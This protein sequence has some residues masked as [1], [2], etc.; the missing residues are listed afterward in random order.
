MHKIETK[1]AQGKKITWIGM[2]VNI[3][4]IAM[5]FAAGVFGHSQA[6]IADAI[7]SISDFFTDFVVVLGLIFGRKPPDETH[8]FGHGR[9]ETVASAIV[10]LALMGVAIFIGV[11]AVGD[12]YHHVE[13]YPTWI[14]IAAAAVSIGLKEILYRY[15]VMVGRRIR[16]QAVIANAWHHRSDALS[17][18]A[19]LIGVTGAQIR[20]GWHILDAYAA[21]LVSFFI[22]KVGID[23]LGEAMRELTDTAPKPEV[24]EKIRGCM[25]AVEGVKGI[26]DLKV[27]STGGTFE[28]LVHL[29]VDKTLSVAQGHIIINEARNC[30]RAEMEDVGEIAVHIDPV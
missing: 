3:L 16:S 26:H 5:K 24:V 2:A 10:G 27:R 18:V 6:L 21:L 8:H 19:V 28:I 15:T 1:E 9:I 14:T 20:P 30:L 11:S 4:L 23:V 12:I 13:R 7:H 25:Q 29:E 17:S 22:V